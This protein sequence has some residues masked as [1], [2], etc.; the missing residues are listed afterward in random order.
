MYRKCC[1]CISSSPWET[2]THSGTV[3]DTGLTYKPPIRQL[4]YTG[5]TYGLPSTSAIPSARRSSQPIEHTCVCQVPPHRATLNPERTTPELTYQTCRPLYLLLYS[6]SN[7]RDPPWTSYH[8]L[9]CSS[10][11]ATLIHHE[12]SLSASPLSPSLFPSCGLNIPPYPTSN[13]KN[14]PSTSM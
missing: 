4:K 8:Y 10:L 7:M 14:L 1:I 6:P 3:E 5:T 12:P 2:A 9:C 11:H 13:L